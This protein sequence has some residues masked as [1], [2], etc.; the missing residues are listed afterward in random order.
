MIYEELLNQPVKPWRRKWY[1]HRVGLQNQYRPDL[2][3][4]VKV[5]VLHK[6]AIPMYDT[7]TQTITI[8]PITHYKTVDDYYHDLFHEASHSLRGRN[9]VYGD[10][11]RRIEEAVAEYSAV[12]LTEQ[13]NLKYDLSNSARYILDI[14]PPGFFFDHRKLE[15]AADKRARK[16]LERQSAETALQG[17]ESSWV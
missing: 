1:V 13:F 16:I 8:P 6:L 5:P 17:R 9:P 15:A 4:L 10:Y 7:L 12:K 2:D 3:R 14:A 11:F